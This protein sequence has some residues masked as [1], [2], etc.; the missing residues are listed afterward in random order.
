MV[1]VIKSYILLVAQIYAPE[2]KLSRIVNGVKLADTIEQSELTDTDG[3]S[4]V[5]HATRFVVDN[6]KTLQQKCF[7]CNEIRMLVMITLIMKV[8]YS[9]A[10]VVIQDQRYL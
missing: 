5:K 2:L 8:A 7:I 1:A 10:I 3:C 9:I 6:V 4:P